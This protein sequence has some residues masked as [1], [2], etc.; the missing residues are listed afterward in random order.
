MAHVWI[1]V[2]KRSGSVAEHM[3]SYQDLQVLPKKFADSKVP[4]Q[5]LQ[6]PDDRCWVW[7]AICHSSSAAECC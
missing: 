2:S 6:I 1:K 4:C 5:D 3:F 7:G